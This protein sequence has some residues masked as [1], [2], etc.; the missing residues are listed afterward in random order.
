M[1]QALAVKS[2]TTDKLLAKIA[3]KSAKVV[4]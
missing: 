2:A 4:F 1:Q 3:N